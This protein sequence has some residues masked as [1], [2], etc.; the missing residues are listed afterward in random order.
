VSRSAQDVLLKGKEVN[1]YVN[2]IL[3]AS[4][5]MFPCGF[6]DDFLTAHWSDLASGDE[7]VGYRK[8]TDVSGHI[9]VT[10]GKTSRPG[11]TD[12][13]PGYIRTFDPAPSGETL[14]SSTDVIRVMNRIRKILS[15]IETRLTVSQDNLLAS[16]QQNVKIDEDT[17]GSVA[18]TPWTTADIEDTCKALRDDSI[19]GCSMY[20]GE[21][22]RMN[23][24]Y[25]CLFALNGVRSINAAAENRAYD[26]DKWAIYDAKPDY[27][28]EYYRRTY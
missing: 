25:K 11:A 9:C 28:G 26:C 10:V 19:F 14:S 15:D 17:Q 6:K 7:T 13:F 27:C 16:R 2:G 22:T 24:E 12:F 21:E 8:L 1:Y 20:P 18:I 23:S 5:L 3:N 4:M